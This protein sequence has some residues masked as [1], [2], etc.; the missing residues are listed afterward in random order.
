MCTKRSIHIC[1]YAAICPSA[2]YAFTIGAKSSKPC[3]KTNTTSCA[4][5]KSPAPED[6]YCSCRYVTILKGVTQ[7]APVA[8]LERTGKV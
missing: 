7:Y 4:G 6:V 1:M 8:G 5:N 3:L 2:A